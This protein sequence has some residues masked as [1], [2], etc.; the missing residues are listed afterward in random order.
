MFLFNGVKPFFLREPIKFIIQKIK[1]NKVT[2]V[3]LIIKYER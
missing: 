1:N 2:G 3:N